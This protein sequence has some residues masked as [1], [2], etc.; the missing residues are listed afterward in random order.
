MFYIILLCF[1][2]YNQNF[3]VSEIDAEIK[4]AVDV[5]EKY[6]L[7]LYCGEFGCYPTTPMDMRASLYKDIMS[8]FSEHGI[9]WSHWNYKNDF[10]LIDE[11]L[12]P[13]HELV[14]V[15]VPHE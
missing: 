11:N 4:Q 2:S 15:L 13:Y 7:Q 6:G 8:I 1:Q 10:P 5:S 9:A 3:S 12:M 14:D